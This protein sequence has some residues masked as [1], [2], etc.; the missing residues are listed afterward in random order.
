MLDLDDL[1][2]KIAAAFEAAGALIMAERLRALPLASATRGIW[3]LTLREATVEAIDNGVRVSRLPLNNSTAE[4]MLKWRN[5]ARALDTHG[6]EIA[7]ALGALDAVEPAP[8]AKRR[9]A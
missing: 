2:L 4:A 7:M 8:V 3:L 5:V 6:A 1:I 9:A